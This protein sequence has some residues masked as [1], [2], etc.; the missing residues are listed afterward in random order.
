MRKRI[1]DSATTPATAES[2]GDWLNLELLAEVEVS[3][4]DPHAPIEAAFALHN[5]GG[6]RAARPG[7]QTIRLLFDT[8]QDLCRIE[9]LFIE[10][11]RER[12]QEFVLRW[13]AEGGPMREIVRQQF[14][15]SPGGAGRE[16][17]S[18]A[19]SL[20]KVRVLELHIIPDRNAGD[21][22]ATLAQMRVA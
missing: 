16:F 1:F 7:E 6:W 20:T 10:E 17:E 12:G 19:V 9:V 8:P 15:F 4:E 13:A 11:A 3:S 2:Q 22:I 21:A 14:H 18:Y 5:S